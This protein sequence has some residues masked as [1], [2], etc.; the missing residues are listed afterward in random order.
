MSRRQNL[1]AS[2]ASGSGRAVPPELPSW[3]VEKDGNSDG[4]VQMSAFAGEWTDERLD[5]FARLRAAPPFPD[6]YQTE[7][8]GRG[9]KGLKQFYGLSMAGTW[10]LLIEANSDRPG[11]SLLGE[12]PPLAEVRQSG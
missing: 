12:R 1:V 9:G 4:Q 2:C 3:F 7:D 8:L 10:A 5:E 6:R 11:V